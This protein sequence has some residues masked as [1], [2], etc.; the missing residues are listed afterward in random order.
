M[1]EE[2]AFERHFNPYISGEPVRRPEMFFA[3]R[4][5]LNRIAG[6]LHQNSVMI[7]GERRIGKTSL[8]Y[9]LADLLRAT[10]DPEWIFIPV[11]V[12]LEGTPQEQF[13]HLM[14]DATLDAVR[15]YLP[16]GEPMLYFSVVPAVRYS[17]RDFTADLRALLDALKP[18]MAP[19]LP[20]LVLM[21]DEVDVI[22]GY[23][24]LTQQQLRRIL[25]SDLAE[26][27]G[28]VV[29]GAYINK[30]WMRE[31]SPWYNLFYEITLEP[32]S[33][34][35]ARRLLVEPV[36]GIYEW[37]AEALDYLVGLANGRPHRLQQHAFAVVN[38]MLA[39]R[40][41]RITLVD[42]MA[43]EEAIRKTR[44]DSSLRSE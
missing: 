15:G 5:L 23:D 25:V 31:E 42:V 34:A 2:L 12:D 8:L 14:M 13:F 24:T 40:R 19:H 20:R 11:M 4:D 37:D 44:G 27:V 22:N 41:L 18:G 39:E 21:L 29:A 30:T 32:F 28:A 3:R 38:H 43:A 26:N 9:Q 36:Q 1:R 17:D 6:G 35:E 33:D 16:T 10:D 7:Q